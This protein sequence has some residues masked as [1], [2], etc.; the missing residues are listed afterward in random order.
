MV[1]ID[2]VVTFSLGGIVGFVVSELIK[3]RLARIRGIEAIRIVEFNKAAAEF[4]AAFVDY[5]YT[6]RHTK[7]MTEHD[8]GWFNMRGIH[9]DT[10]E[11]DHEKAKIRFEPFINKSD[12]AGFDAA[13]E[14]YRQWPEHFT[15]QD[16]KTDRKDAVLKYLYSLLE[17]AN[18]KI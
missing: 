13:W 3:D 17:Y 5:I 1:A 14:K 11:R 10:V 6:L 12:Q 16:D 2:S 8:E 9:T 18:P 15:K 7:S 4:R